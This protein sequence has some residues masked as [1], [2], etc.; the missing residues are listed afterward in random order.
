M[1][2]FQYQ[3]QF[4]QERFHNVIQYIIVQIIYDKTIIHSLRE[5]F[6]ILMDCHD[7]QLLSELKNNII[8]AFYISLL[9]TNNK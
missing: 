2:Y 1:A 9:Y 3:N 8:K 7:G 4:I 5:M 6:H